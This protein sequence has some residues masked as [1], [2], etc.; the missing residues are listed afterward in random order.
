MNRKIKFSLL[1]GFPA[2]AYFVYRNYP[3]LNI[4]TGFAAKTACSCTF[5]ADRDLI[6][7][8]AG[9]NAFFPV[10]YAENKIDPKEKSVT[11]SVLGMKS[12]K[13]IYK[14]GIGCIL[15]PEK[16]EKTPVTI[17]KRNV[18]APPMTSLFPTAMANRKE[19]FP[20]K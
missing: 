15:L 19:Q 13:A 3:K 9:E 1:A 10:K 4:I 6:S 8:E 17:P 20:K 16:V 18:V 14:E 12:R 7:I 2:L 11:S 5:L